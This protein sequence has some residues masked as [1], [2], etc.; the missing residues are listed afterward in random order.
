MDDITQAEALRL[1]RLIKIAIAFDLL[2]KSGDD[3]DITPRGQRLLDDIAA[4]SGFPPELQGE[5][6]GKIALLLLASDRLDQE[7]RDDT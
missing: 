1:A 7:N 2:Q 3:L 4:Q 6:L 5:P